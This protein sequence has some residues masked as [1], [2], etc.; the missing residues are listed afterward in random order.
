[1]FISQKNSFINSVQIALNEVHGNWGEFS[2]YKSYGDIVTLAEIGAAG[3]LGA[4]AGG[5]L[6]YWILHSCEVIP[7]QTDEPTSFDVWWQI[8]QGLHSV[9]G[10][11]TDMWINDNVTSNFGLWVGLGAGVVPAW[12]LEVA[13]NSLY[14][15]NDLLYTD[16]NRGI[17]EPMG[18]PSSVSVCGH[19]DDTAHEIAGLEKPTCLFEFW[20]DN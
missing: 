8:F 13:A 12:F 20:L 9:V 14:G 3:G 15:P 17:S 6:A 11:R 1:M 19:V 4:D 18:R 7:T 16:S 2:T 10:Y 5:C